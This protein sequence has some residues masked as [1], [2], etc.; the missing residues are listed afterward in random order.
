GMR[1]KNVFYEESARVPLMI[2][3]PKG[4]Q[5]NTTV[6]GYVSL[7]DLFATIL[8]YCHVPAPPSNGSSL[9][10]LINGKVDSKETYVVTEWLPKEDNTPNYM[11]VKDGWKMFIP[12]SVE[13][14]VINVLYNLNEDPHELNNLIGNNPNKA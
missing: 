10:G 14:K 1:E 5:S 3:Y 2:R 6:S 9:R 7:I 12:Y 4:I 13:S 8:D 11:I